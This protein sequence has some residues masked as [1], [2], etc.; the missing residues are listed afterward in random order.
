[1]IA[2]EGGWGVGER[3]VRS[4][5]PSGC[6]CQQLL[7]IPKKSRVLRRVNTPGFRAA[8]RESFPENL[9]LRPL[10][11]FPGSLPR[12]VASVGTD[13]A[14]GSREWRPGAACLAAIWLPVGREGG[15]APSLGNGQLKLSWQGAKL[16]LGPKH[17]GIPP[18]PWA[19]GGS[20]PREQARWE[21]LSFCGGDCSRAA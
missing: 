9:T 19:T 1:M 16:I 2:M 5:L 4:A 18:F 7:P 3:P 6:L 20:S 8:R 17:L 21:G 14:P 10:E 13:E 15:G 11:S 12:K